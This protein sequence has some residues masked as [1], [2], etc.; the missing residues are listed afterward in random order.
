MYDMATR[1]QV[2]FWQD[3]ELYSGD[4][5]TSLGLELKVALQLDFEFSKIELVI[6]GI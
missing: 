3:K 6:L 2:R 1:P 4:M 5:L